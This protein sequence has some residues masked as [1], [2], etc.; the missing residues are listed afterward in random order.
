MIDTDKYEGHT[1]AEHWDF[2][3]W[4]ITMPTGFEADAELIADA[5][6]LLEEVK[7]LRKMVDDYKAIMERI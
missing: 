6:L 5:P 2:S 7:R 1:S 3:I 4:G